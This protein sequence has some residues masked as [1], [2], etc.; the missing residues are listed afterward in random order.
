MS[1]CIA[2]V[3][4]STIYGNI[5]SVIKKS[6]HLSADNTREEKQKKIHI[7]THALTPGQRLLIP[8][9]ISRRTT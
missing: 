8:P 4:F 7:P 2:V 9:K 5:D 1:I 3:D 6:C